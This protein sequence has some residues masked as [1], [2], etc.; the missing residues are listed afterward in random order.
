VHVGNYEVPLEARIRFS[1]VENGDFEVLDIDPERN[2]PSAALIRNVLRVLAGKID[3]L[4]RRWCETFG[5]VCLDGKWVRELPR[6]E[7][8]PQ[9]EVLRRTQK[10][11]SRVQA[12]ISNHGPA[13]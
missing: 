10:N 11:A 12:W 7:G 6:V 1:F 4:R 5:T 8:E 2:E 13:N 3:F 9:F